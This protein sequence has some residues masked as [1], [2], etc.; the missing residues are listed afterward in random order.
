M[1][2]QKSQE[3]DFL[4]TVWVPACSYCLCEQWGHLVNDLVDGS[5]TAMTAV[6][7]LLH[8][9]NPTICKSDGDLTAAG[10]G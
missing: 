10:T 2:A 3:G 5:L 1:H 9:T 7:A 4:T 6:R 8:K